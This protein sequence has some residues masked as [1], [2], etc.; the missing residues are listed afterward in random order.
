M[1]AKVE[2]RSLWGIEARKVEVE[3]DI[4]GGLPCFNIVGLADTAVKESKDRVISA[5]KNSGFKLPPKRITINLPPICARK[6]QDMT[7]DSCR[8]WRQRRA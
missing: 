6:A 1:L 3:V 8:D 7:G 4:T 2:S 5:I